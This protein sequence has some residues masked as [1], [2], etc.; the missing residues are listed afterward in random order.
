MKIVLPTLIVIILA[1]AAYH[2]L[3]GDEKRGCIP[4]VIYDTDCPTV[5]EMKR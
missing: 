1:G 2:T 4:V 5:G 3:F